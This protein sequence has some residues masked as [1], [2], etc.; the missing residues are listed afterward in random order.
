[1]RDTTDKEKDLRSNLVLTI[2]GEIK[3]GITIGIGSYEHSEV[4]ESP[5]AEE[6]VTQE[7]LDK[8][9]VY[10]CWDDDRSSSFDICYLIPKE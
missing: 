4:I 5:N 6:K 1:M 2:D 3:R 9:T 10:H 7:I 8:Y